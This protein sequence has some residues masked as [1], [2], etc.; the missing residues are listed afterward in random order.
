MKALP[1]LGNLPKATQEAVEKAG[2]KENIEL[3]CY[4]TPQQRS[5]LESPKIV[6]A[7]PFGSGKT[8]LM[9]I[10]AIELAEAG[11]DVLFLIF[12]DGRANPSGKKTLLCL[13]L[14][15]K[16]KKHPKIIVKMVPFVNG[17]TDNMKGNCDHF[18]YW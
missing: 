12:V 6:F 17:K 18:L 13:D 8:L 5:I 9:T 1:V 3:W 4:P 15:Q 14:E 10:R 2:T 11:E 16:F 7:A